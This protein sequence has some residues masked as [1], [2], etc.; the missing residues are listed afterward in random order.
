[1]IATVLVTIISNVITIFT[2]FRLFLQDERTFPQYSVAFACIIWNTTRTMTT[3][4]AIHN[5]SEVT[6]QVNDIFKLLFHIL[7]NNN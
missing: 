4:I 5:A 3:F 1:M 7:W 2:L 6:S